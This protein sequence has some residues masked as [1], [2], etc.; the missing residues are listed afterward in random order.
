MNS[1]VFRN[2]RTAVRFSESSHISLTLA[3]WML[4]AFVGRFASMGP[5]PKVYSP[6]SSF[7]TTMVVFLV[8]KYSCRLPMVICLSFFGSAASTTSKSVKKSFFITTGSPVRALTNLNLK[9]TVLLQLTL[10]LP[11]ALPLPVLSGLPETFIFTVVTSRSTFWPMTVVM[12]RYRKLQAY[13][14][15]SWWERSTNV[16]S[17]SKSAHPSSLHER[18]SGVT[19]WGSAVE[20]RRPVATREAFAR[21]ETAKPGTP[22]ALAVGG[23]TIFGRTSSGHSAR[24]SPASVRL[25]SS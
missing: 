8:T 14:L 7:S 12:S 1:E 9:G 6:L 2:M 17:K 23:A 4:R 16:F 13:L 10:I 20:S 25:Y 21:A 19:I 24:P 5:L 3:C 15:S 11:M 18:R 22:P